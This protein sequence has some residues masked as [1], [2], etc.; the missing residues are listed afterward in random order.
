M[1]PAKKPSMLSWGLGQ[2]G[3]CDDAGDGSKCV[4]VAYP[5]RNAPTGFLTGGG[6]AASCG[7]GAVVRN[8]RGEA[9]LAGWRSEVRK[10]GRRAGRRAMV[11]SSRG[12]DRLP[13]WRSWVVR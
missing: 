4:L 11:V 6:G 12:F 2:L 9:R 7:L 5:P 8:V 1:L 3:F 13:E 10:V